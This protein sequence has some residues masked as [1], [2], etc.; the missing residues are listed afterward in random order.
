MANPII[1]QLFRQNLWA[2][3]AILDVLEPLGDR[4]RDVV[5]EGIFAD[6]YTTM[7]HVIG[8]ETGYLARIRQAGDPIPWERGEQPDWERLR[9]VATETG[10]RYMQLARDLEGDPIQRGEYRGHPYEMPTSLLL[11]QSYN[12]GVDHRSQVKTALTVHGIAFPELDG[13]T[14]DES[15]AR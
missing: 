13:W 8:S 9:S 14:W 1:E 2:N 5:V 7:V 11:I 6:A 12:H 3:L 10:T 4:A 15:T